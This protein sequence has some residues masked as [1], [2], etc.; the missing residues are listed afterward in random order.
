[1]IGRFILVCHHGFG[2]KS[3]G[4][5]RRQ[6]QIAFMRVQTAQKF[7]VVG[8]VDCA[9]FPS[10]HVLSILATDINYPSATVV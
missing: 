1:M 9:K 10:R 5:C 6:D 8:G 3:A 7:D 2:G 4:P